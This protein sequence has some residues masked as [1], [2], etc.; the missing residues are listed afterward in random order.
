MRE[1]I[2]I[3]SLL[4]FIAQLPP[5]TEAIR[6]GGEPKEPERSLMRM[7]SRSYINRYTSLHGRTVCGYVLCTSTLQTLRA[8]LIFMYHL[9]RLTLS[10]VVESSMHNISFRS[11]LPTWAKDNT[12]TT[13]ITN[14]SWNGLIT[15]L[16]DR[17]ITIVGLIFS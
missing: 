17:P 2:I 1:A 14:F 15:P 5:S 13:G 10:V 11:A 12:L 4:S 16:P 8:S 3:I 6:P 9:K 7:F